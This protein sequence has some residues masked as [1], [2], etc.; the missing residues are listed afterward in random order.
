METITKV[1]K[2]KK[3]KQKKLIKVMNKVVTM[4]K[5]LN[6]HKNLRLKDETYNRLIKAEN[7]TT[8]SLWTIIK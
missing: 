5:M 8:A 6:K 1:K 4:K 3:K 2:R 7:A